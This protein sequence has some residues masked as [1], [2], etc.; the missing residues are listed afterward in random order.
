MKMINL[1]HETFIREMLAHSMPQQAYLAAYPNAAP[2]TLRSAP[3]R[4]LARTDI[5]TRLLLAYREKWENARSG[6]E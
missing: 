1:A 2:A 6:E 4:L 5:A 3:Y